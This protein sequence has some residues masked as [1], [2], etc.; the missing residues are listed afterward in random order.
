MPEECIWV[1]SSCPARTR[2]DPLT[3]TVA[4]TGVTG[5]S[6][7]GPNDLDT[8]VRLDGGGARPVAGSI[9]APAVL[10]G[11]VLTRP[12]TARRPVTVR[13]IRAGVGPVWRSRAGATTR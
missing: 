4:R 5:T 6:W 1:P 2:T 3:P 12:G 11:L 10:A 7:T 13:P 8:A 9:T